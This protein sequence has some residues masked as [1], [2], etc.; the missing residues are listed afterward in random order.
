MSIAQD[1]LAQEAQVYHALAKKNSNRAP[2]ISV[3][4]IFDPVAQLLLYF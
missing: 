4:F 3:G 2:I 1:L